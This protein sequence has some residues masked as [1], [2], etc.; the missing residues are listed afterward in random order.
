MREIRSSGSVGGAPQSNAASLPLSG[1]PWRR[2]RSPTR[3][4]VRSSLRDGT[5]G[6]LTLILKCWCG[7]HEWA[8]EPRMAR[9]SRMV[10]AWEGW[11]LWLGFRMG[12]FWHP[13]TDRCSETAVL[14][15]PRSSAAFG[16][17]FGSAVCGALARN[18]VAP[19]VSS[20]RGRRRSCAAKQRPLLGWETPATGHRWACEN[21]K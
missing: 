3:G 1:A 6:V 11:G 14:G 2:S 5:M 16:A 4:S 9:M 17:G 15:A 8:W 12:R 21:L 19:S 13:V 7:S 20:R 18:D 10:S